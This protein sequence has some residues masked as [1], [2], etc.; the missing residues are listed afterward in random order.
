MYQEYVP[1]VVIRKVDETVFKNLK[2]CNP[3]LKGQIVHILF[4]MRFLVS[5]LFIMSVM[6]Y[7]CKSGNK[8]ANKGK[9]LPQGRGISRP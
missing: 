9:E 8:N 7:L 6:E 5:T 1:C 2:G 3:G 4:H